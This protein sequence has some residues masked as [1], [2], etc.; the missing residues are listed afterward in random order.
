M[1][2]VP[3]GARLT[4]NNMNAWTARK[5]KRLALRPPGSRPLRSFASSLLRTFLLLAVQLFEIFSGQFVLRVDLQRALE[6]QP[7]LLYI[8]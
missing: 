4:D 5:L 7:R 2:R 1:T 3:L 8:P 6:M